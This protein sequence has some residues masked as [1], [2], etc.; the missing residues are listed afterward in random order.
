M[1]TRLS[2]IF[3]YWE[4]ILTT[5]CIIVPKI[6]DPLCKLQLGFITNVIVS[7]PHGAQQLKNTR[8]W[9]CVYCI[10]KNI[11]I[12][13]WIS[14]IIIYLF[15]F[16]KYIIIYSFYFLKY[17]IIHLFYFLNVWRGIGIVID[18]HIYIS[19]RMVDEYHLDKLKYL[20]MIVKETLILP[21]ERMEGWQ[22]M[23]T[24]TK[25]IHA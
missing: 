16:L 25:Q 9:Y 10:K 13:L 6:M 11:L 15:Y 20:D 17:I 19:F 1:S 21:H 14:N 22:S 3:I 4:R 8:F 23:T 18:I 24:I 12:W 5:I 7:F 2:V